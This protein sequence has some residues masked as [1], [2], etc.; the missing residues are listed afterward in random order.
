MQGHMIHRVLCFG[1]SN[2]FGFDPADKIEKRYPP[3]QRWPNILAQNTGWEVINMGLNG[4]SIPYSRQDVTLAISQIQKKL[5]ADLLIIML[6]TNDAFKLGNPSAEKI[7]ARMDAFL[8]RLRDSFPQLS[9]FLISPPRVEIP[10]AH[11]QEIFWELIPK[12][13]SVAAKYHALFAAAPNWPL[14][15][16]ADEV[17]ISA[18]ANAVF[19]A[20]VEAHIC[21]PG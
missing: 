11:I 15:L 1:D 10:P 7:S 19:A 16:T 21:G 12:Y 2:T 20:Q 14:Q 4:R 13:R 17:H 18:E 6:G 3:Y 5:P 9:I 8:S